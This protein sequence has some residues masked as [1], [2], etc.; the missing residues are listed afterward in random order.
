MSQEAL[1]VCC[2]SVYSKT[3][4]SLFLPFPYYVWKGMVLM[5]YKWLEAKLTRAFIEMQMAA[6]AVK[7]SPKMSTKTAV[8]LE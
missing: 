3:C 8:V 7:M 5:K 6:P 4:V 1:S 2:N